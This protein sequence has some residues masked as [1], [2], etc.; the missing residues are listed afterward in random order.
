MTHRLWTLVG[1][2]VT[3]LALASVGFVT[4]GVAATGYTP[5]AE[6]ALGERYEAM[7]AYYL[8]TQP[9][10]SPA[11][12]R[13]MGERYEAMADWYWATEPTYPPAALEAIGQRYD[14]MADYYTGLEATA[15]PT[16]E[17]T[18]A[19]H[20]TDAAI[21]ALAVVGVGAAVALLVVETRRHVHHPPASPAA[22]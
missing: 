10:L 22:R 21:G 16:A 9:T 11:A 2:M 15:E 7:A 1:V 5:E 20:W 17:P 4:A 8:G 12:L 3:L 6:R 13:A 19:F 14:A 18:S